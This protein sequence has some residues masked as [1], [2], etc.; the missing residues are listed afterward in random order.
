MLYKFE[1]F[2]LDTT[3]VELRQNGSAI[4]LEPQVFTLLALLVTHSKRMVSKDE[5]HDEVWKGRIVSEAALSSRIRTAR[6][7][8]GDDGKSQR[9]IRTVHSNGF[10]F[11]GEV[12]TSDTTETAAPT[13][14]VNEPGMSSPTVAIFP[15]LNLSGD[16]SQEYFSDAITG[17]LIAT[18][19]KHRWLSITARNTTFGFKGSE[20]PTVEL[21][22]ELGV[23]YIVEGSVQRSGNRIRVSVQ[24][25]DTVS[26]VQRWADRYDREIEDLFALQDEITERIA[27]RLEPEI[28]FAERQ[29]VAKTKRL[30]LGA[31]ENFHLG[32]W[33][34]FRFTAEDNMEAQRLLQLSREQDPNFGEA[35]AWWAYAVILGMVYWDTSPSR[36]L[37]DQA[38]DATKTALKE[39][40]KNAVFYALKA[41]VQLARQEYRS[42]II[43]NHQA[44][45]LNST[46]A[47]AHCGLAD[48]LAYEGQY[49]EAIKGFETALE[50]SPNDPQRWAFLTYGALALIFK[51]DY[52]EA[53]A[54][55][56]RAE[57][58]PNCQYWTTAHQAVALAYLGREKETQA[59][60]TR[61]L[62]AVPHFSLSFAEEK[63]FYLKDET[64]LATYLT[65]LKKAGIK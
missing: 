14:E 38:L 56:E 46:F 42:A 22:R 23:S 48:S 40:D 34:F 1:N 11:V 50:L 43:E 39:D 37:L 17:D 27:A 26:G 4:P 53:L 41:R 63:L 25:I 33:H 15:F 20:K 35:H 24:L 47:A 32:V 13:E 44:I 9:L 57:V 64:Q 21:A 29:K 28:G 7:A 12:S 2:E 49:D 10:R 45:E 16:P 18:L 8:I 58:I 54:W 51:G 65:G 62:K 19:S 61:L 30:H 60:V 6:Q 52:E 3:R 55:T 59:A 31:W 5:I 36:D